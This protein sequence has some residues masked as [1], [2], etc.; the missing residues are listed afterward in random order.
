VG[1]YDELVARTA[2]PVVRLNRAVA[3][4]MAD[5]PHVGLG[6]LDGLS[7]LEGYHLFHAARAELL[8]RVGDR[9][10]AAAAFARSIALVQNPAERRHLERRRAS[11][12]VP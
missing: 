2:S 1:L 7:G 3:V 8:L 4:A 5:G 6:E 12:A 10:G 9:A 11:L